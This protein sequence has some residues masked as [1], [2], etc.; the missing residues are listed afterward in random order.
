M[1]VFLASL[2]LCAADRERRLPA[3]LSCSAVLMFSLWLSWCAGDR[4]Y[5]LP[6]LLLCDL[7]RGATGVW[8]VEPGPDYLCLGADNKLYQA[9]P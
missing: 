4:D 8:V 3:L 9:S 1:R 5:R 7:E 2:P 6:A